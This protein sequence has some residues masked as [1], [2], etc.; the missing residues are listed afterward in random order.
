[1]IKF[2]RVLSSNLEF[3]PG[4]PSRKR[5]KY[6]NWNVKGKMATKII[7]TYL[8]T[9]MIMYTCAL[10]ISKLLTVNAQQSTNSDTIA[11]KV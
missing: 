1:M 7:Y 8:V 4:K 9:I 2:I 6:Q 11:G 5:L 10:C 3:K